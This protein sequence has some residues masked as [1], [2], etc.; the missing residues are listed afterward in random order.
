MRGVFANL[1]QV[2][3]YT[4]VDVYAHYLGSAL[5]CYNCESC[6]D[7]FSSGD[8]VDCSYVDGGYCAKIVVDKGKWFY[9]TD[10]TVCVRNW[11]QE[12]IKLNICYFYKLIS[13]IF[14]LI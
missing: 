14:V 7:P 4:C 6:G 2:Q 3:R 11:S 13:S 12:L 5:R 10:T 8:E 1:T 9:N